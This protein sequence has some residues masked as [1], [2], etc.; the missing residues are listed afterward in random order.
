MAYVTIF[1]INKKEMYVWIDEWMDGW[2]DT[3]LIMYF[4]IPISFLPQI[5]V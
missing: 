4:S 2:V 5:R 1:I 3:K